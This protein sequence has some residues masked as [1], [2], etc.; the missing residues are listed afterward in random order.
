[1]FKKKGAYILV[2]GLGAFQS[3]GYGSRTVKWQE[4]G[5][6]IA[7]S[8]TDLPVDV[9]PLATSKLMYLKVDPVG[10][11]H[12]SS[13][14]GHPM[15]SDLR[16]R[17]AEWE[18]LTKLDEEQRSRRH[19][20]TT[21]SSLASLPTPVLDGKSLPKLTQGLCAWRWWRRTRLA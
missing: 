9:L 12:L 1:M 7:D 18:L 15:V 11:S 17:L 14:I 3:G 5:R 19:V 2:A 10:T 20:L 16:K 8:V 6:F 4:G 13:L 21:L